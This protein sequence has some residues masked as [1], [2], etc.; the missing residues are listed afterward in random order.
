MQWKSGI[1]VVA[2]K[3]QVGRVEKDNAKT[4]WMR[5]NDIPG[6]PLLKIKRDRVHFLF[7]DK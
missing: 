2:G 6:K 1:V 4:C 5:F 7:G 3:K